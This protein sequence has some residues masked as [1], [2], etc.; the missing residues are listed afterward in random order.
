MD[1]QTTALL[2]VSVVA[3]T[4]SM[5][6]VAMRAGRVRATLENVVRVLIAPVAIIVDILSLLIIGSLAELD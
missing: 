4:A 2:L 6:D 1:L 5:T 3:A